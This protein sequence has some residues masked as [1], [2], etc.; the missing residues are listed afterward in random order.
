[1]NN[2]AVG[3]VRVSTNHQVDNGV[4]LEAQRVKIEGYAAMNSLNLEIIEDA[5]LSGKTLDNRP[6]MTRLLK[7]VHSRKVSMIVVSKVDRISRSVSDL[8]RLIQLFNK[9]GVEFVSIGDAIDTSSASGRLSINILSSV[10]QWEAE[11]AGERT[12]AALQQL[13]SEGRRIS[14]FAP[15]GFKFNGSGVVEDMDEQKAVQAIHKLRQ[16]GLSLRRI[17]AELERR[18]FC[19]R[20]GKVLSAQTINSVLKRG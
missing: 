15:Y 5:G 8:N 3:Y 6:G 13:K 12:S 2:K 14:R 4:S 20:S 17:G 1:M 16:S 11:A 9:N 18:G 19:S 10:S 7:L